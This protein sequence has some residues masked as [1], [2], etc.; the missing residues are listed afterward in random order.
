MRYSVSFGGQEVIGIGT[1]QET[2]KPSQKRQMRVDA[3]GLGVL[4]LLIVSWSFGPLIIHRFFHLG[5]SIWDQNAVRYTLAA[6]MVWLLIG[7][8]YRRQQSELRSQLA[9]GHWRRSLVPAVPGLVLQITLSWALYKIQPGLLSLL[10]KQYVI[11]AVFLAMLAFPEERRLLQQWRFWVGFACVIGGGLGVLLL[12][13]DLSYSS[14]EWFGLILVFIFA[15]STALYSV[16]VRAL[17]GSQSD[18]MVFYGILALYVFVPLWVPSIAQG[19]I[20]TWGSW[21]VEAW[22]LMVISSLCNI[23]L[24]HMAYFWVVRR[25]GVTISNTVMMTTAFTTT[26]LSWWFYGERLQ[27]GQ[28]LGGAVLV[29]GAV[30]TVL[31]E[32][33]LQGSPQDAIDRPEPAD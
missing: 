8:K 2:R 26:L 3:A 29:S 31:S 30:L 12:K 11:W 22:A 32:Q 33:R 27:W 9:G 4:A 17:M 6:G 23:A 16:S 1:E 21:P 20:G 10:H 28:W 19:K 5:I 25:M 7:L 24:S 15:V 13:S 14:E 18:P